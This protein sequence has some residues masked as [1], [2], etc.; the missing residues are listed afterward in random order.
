[1]QLKLPEAKMHATLGLGE[2]IEV[3]WME[4]EEQGWTEIVQRGCSLEM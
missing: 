1:M 2:Q 4:E 3:V